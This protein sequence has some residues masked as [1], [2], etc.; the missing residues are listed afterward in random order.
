MCKV[1]WCDVPIEEGAHFATKYCTTHRQYKTYGKNA[2]SRPWLFYK[3]EKIARGELKCEC[4][5]YE[6]TQFYGRDLKELSGLLDV[7][8]INSDIK[9][10]EKGEHPSNY[11]LICKHCHI[12]KSYD[13]GDYI[14]KDYR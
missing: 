1:T 6:P 8:H 5:G 3:V 14:R 10:T 12:L 4:C 7:D 13:N 2:Y 9:H 11:Q